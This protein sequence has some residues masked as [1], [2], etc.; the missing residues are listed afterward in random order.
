MDSINKKDLDSLIKKSENEETKDQV[1]KYLNEFMEKKAVLGIDVYQ[2]SQYEYVEQTLIPILL[3]EIFNE[4]I[5]CCSELESFAFQNFDSE[6]FMRESIDTGDGGFFFFETP[7]HAVIFAIYFQSNIRRY[8]SAR[9]V[10]NWYLRTIVDNM[11]VRYCLTFDDVFGFNGKLYGPAIINNAR[12]ISMDRLNR[13]LLDENTIDWFTIIMN[14][15]E[16]LQVINTRD[17]TNIH[18]FDNYQNITNEK[19]FFQDNQRPDRGILV[20]DVMKIGEVKAKSNFLDVSSLH[21]KVRLFNIPGIYRFDTFTVTL[22]N[23]NSSGISENIL[24]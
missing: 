6:T 20:T 17:F 23:L 2:Y 9:S 4:T 13:F 8:I 16:N 24:K 14:G 12:I 7:F 3:N 5:H 19:S 18:I 1:N 11:I 15:I 22:G 21:I 10:N